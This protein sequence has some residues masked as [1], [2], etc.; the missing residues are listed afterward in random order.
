MAL[1][2]TGGVV[3]SALA[4]FVTINIR[5]QPWPAT[6]FQS[7]MSSNIHKIAGGEFDSKA[8]PRCLDRHGNI[9][10][11]STRFNRT[12][13]SSFLRWLIRAVLN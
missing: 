4:R 12:P 13:R 10:F 5:A 2:A 7:N 11:N 3:V 6:S 9:E 1:R 8:G